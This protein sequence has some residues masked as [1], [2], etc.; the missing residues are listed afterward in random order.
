[1]RDGLRNMEVVVQ[2]RVVVPPCTRLRAAK[3]ARTQN[4]D[5][6]FHLPFQKILYSLHLDTC[7]FKNT[8]Y[9]RHSAAHCCG[10]M[11]VKDVSTRIAPEGSEGMCSERPWY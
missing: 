4:D 8:V 11:V 3:P 7:G 9:T 2:V 10:Q 1:M 5:S 6:D